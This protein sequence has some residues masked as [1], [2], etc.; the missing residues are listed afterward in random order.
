TNDKPA[1]VTGIVITSILLGA[2]LGLAARQRGIVAPLG[3]AAFGLVRLWA[4]ITDPQ[5]STGDAIFACVVSVLA[6][7]GT[8]ALLWRLPPPPP[9]DPAAG[10]AAGEAPP[11]SPE[12]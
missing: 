9:R 11:T 10:G 3:L 4:M 5:D 6:G 7:I 8:F 2:L 12:S 1:L